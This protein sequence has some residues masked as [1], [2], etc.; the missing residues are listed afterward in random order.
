MTR[1][2]RVA[3][4]ALA[5]A[6]LAASPAYA[7]FEAGGLQPHQMVRS[8]QL[9]Q[10]RI[11]DGDHAALPMQKKLLELTDARFRNAGDADLAD[12]RTFHALM[13]YAMSGG[14]PATVADSLA[15]LEVDEADRTAGAG[16]LGYLT[17]DVA[18]AREAMGSIDPS[19]HPQ[20]VAA[21][22]YLVKGSVVGV[23]DPKAGIA[24][25]DHARL[26]GPGT[27]V[28]EAALRRTVALAVTAEAGAK[29]TS[30]S[31]QYAR[32]FLRSPY[33]SQFAQ[34]FVSGITE[35]KHSLDLD[36]IEQAIAWMTHEQAR[37]VYLRLARSAAIDGDKTLLDFAARKA[38]EYPPAGGAAE[39]DPRSEL[40]SSIS[41]VTSETVEEVLARLIEL[42]PAQLSADDR[43]LLNAAKAVATEVVAPVGKTA[44]P[45][46]EPDTAPD[47]LADAGQAATPLS[48]DELVSSTRAKLEAI[49]KM[50]QETGQ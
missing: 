8:L 2:L 50:L 7:D 40:Y 10:D 35:L 16:V 45:L 29:F 33:S 22:L 49:D 36:R 4:R 46:R 37:V 12:R 11:A 26:L 48:T 31:E 21:F 39:E 17:G 41:S 14:N 32:R 38:R 18:Q 44:L 23:E 19:D 24:M 1:P 25:L 15:R 5:L 43:A 13:I 47:T 3:V 34:S 30:A 9:V 6:A 28:E 20:E 42:D 27:L